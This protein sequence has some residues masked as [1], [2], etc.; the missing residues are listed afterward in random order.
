MIPFKEALEIVLQSAKTLGVEKSD[1]ME[2]VGKVLAE[3]IQSDI[4]MPPFDKSAMDGYAC[5][6][7]DI[8]NELTIVEEIP[9]GSFPKIKIKENECAK[10]MTGAPVPE[11]ADMVIMVEHTR[12][13][14]DNKIIYLKESSAFNI[15]KLA[16]DVKAGEVVLKKGTIIEPKHIPVLASVG[17]TEVLVYKSPKVAI[18]ATG[19]E[20]VEPGFKPEPSQIRNSN[21]YQMIA[22]AQ[23]LGLEVE[24][25]GLAKDTMEDSR[26]MLNKA[27]RTADIIILS[28]AVSMGDFDFVPAVIKEMGVKILFHGVQTKPG[29]RTIFGT[30]KKQ[31]FVGL[32]GNPVS[33]YVQFE[34][35]IKPLIYKIMG[36]NY[37]APVYRMPMYE[38][39]HRK[40]A[41]HKAFEPVVITEDGKVKQ[42]EYH[43]SAHIH[44][45][46]YAQA[47]MIIEPGVT[48]LKKGDLT[49][50]RPI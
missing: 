19:N 45:L 4:N 34:M 23:Q 25:L 12:R 18:I 13:L 27:C 1:F 39:Y 5:R 11:G 17:A 33:S 37:Q 43:G 42:V 48:T 22:Q 28:G 2:S 15:C 46:S 16:E 14:S 26:R 24:Y 47:F 38:D 49:D 50:V 44:A 10:I 8:A 30:G 29:K 7:L 40:K 32:P 3:D 9:A 21:A 35:L 31:W 41:F 6:H 20:L 36:A